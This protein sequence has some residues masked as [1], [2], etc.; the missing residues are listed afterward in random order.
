M[1]TVPHNIYQIIVV[2]AACIVPCLIGLGIY[3]SVLG[4]G[5]YI[6][7]IWAAVFLSVVGILLSLRVSVVNSEQLKRLQIA[8]DRIAAGDFEKIIEMEPRNDIGRLGLSIN[9]MA[10]KF[11]GMYRAMVSER[12]KMAL[13]ISSI[14]DA[15]FVVDD[16]GRITMMNKAAER[17]VQVPPEKAI[18][19][20]FIEIVRDYELDDVLQRCL[21]T[22]KQQ[23]GFVETKPKKQY[24]SMIIT[25]LQVADN[26]NSLIRIQDLT[27]LRR[28]EVVRQDFISN[29]SHELRTP[30]SSVKALA[31]TLKDNAVDDPSVAKDFLSKINIEADRLAQM[32][33]ELSELSRIEK[34]I[35]QLNKKPIHMVEI[36]KYTL[37]RLK[38]QANR[39]GITITLDIS[40]DL[41]QVLADET[42][43]EQVLINLIHNAIKFT[44]TDGR[45]H[46]SATEQGGAVEVSISDTGIGISSDDL[47]R[48]FERFYKADKSRSS[49]G[50]GLGLAI[51]KHI[52][53]AH[54]GRIWADSIEGQ[55]STFRFTLPLTLE[56]Q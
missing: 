18:G 29:I 28:L 45:I 38:A 52:V 1:V 46:V 39:A 41:P 15:I 5:D 16:T 24:F 35:T 30:I 50:T 56:P 43:I 6:A 9:A 20:A 44:P 21:K 27:E 19:R 47:P 25:P 3:I 33:Q 37:E 4:E 12:D 26:N 11:R 10:G 22:G 13:I 51:A 32:V 54:R 49:R 23:S 53:E 36:I 17:V 2:F 14:D 34:G 7:L 42:R 31:E 8:C 55:G 40:Q 48:I